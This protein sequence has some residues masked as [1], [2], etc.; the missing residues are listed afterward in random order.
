[1]FIISWRACP[2]RSQVFFKFHESWLMMML[3]SEVITLVS[4]SRHYPLMSRH[5]NYSKNIFITV[6]ISQFLPNIFHSTSVN[7]PKKTKMA[8]RFLET[9]L[10]YSV[11]VHGAKH[12]KNH[13][14]K[15][16]ILQLRVLYSLCVS[17]VLLPG[18]SP[19]ISPMNSLKYIRE[20]LTII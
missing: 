2:M 3:N 20:G 12:T 10:V 14:W 6:L 16:F 4:M 8:S 13:F 1:M 9:T 19:S 5:V 15:R 7:S 18:K 17:V 11:T